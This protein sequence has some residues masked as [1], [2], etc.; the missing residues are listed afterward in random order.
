MAALRLVVEICEPPFPAAFPF[1]VRGSGGRSL[2]E[3]VPMVGR[4]VACAAS[5]VNE[6]RVKF[7]WEPLL[8]FK[9]KPSANRPGG[10][11][12]CLFF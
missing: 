1:P 12:V 7:Y 4:D 8:V 3:W 2:R 11:F 5:C 9:Y 10:F 6:Q